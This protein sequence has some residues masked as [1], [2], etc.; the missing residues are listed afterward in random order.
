MYY[1]SKH[2]GV[3]KATSTP[4]SF[5]PSA[6]LIISTSPSNASVIDAM[7]SFVRLEMKQVLNIIFGN[8]EFSFVPSIGYF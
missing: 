2:G 3:S 8:T 7:S 1:G 4:P 5:F 6:N